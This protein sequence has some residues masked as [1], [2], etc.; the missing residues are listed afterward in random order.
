ML[1]EDGGYVIGNDGNDCD[2]YDVGC[3]DE[4]IHDEGGGYVIGNDGNDCDW[5]DV[6]D[7]DDKGIDGGYVI[8]NDCD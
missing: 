4:G 5:Y 8:G 2:W 3:D 6:D 7:C 1:D